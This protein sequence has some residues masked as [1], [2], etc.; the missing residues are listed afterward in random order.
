MS[1]WRPGEGEI[2][3]EREIT[4][5][6]FQDFVITKALINVTV[7]QVKTKIFFHCESV[8]YFKSIQI[9]ILEPVFVDSRRFCLWY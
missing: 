3:K 1:E 6:L 4:Y 8:R 7:K 2:L 9:F 5:E